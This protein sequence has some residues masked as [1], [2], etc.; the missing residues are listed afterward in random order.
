MEGRSAAVAGRRELE[1]L[2]YS[3]LNVSWCGPESTK[4]ILMETQNR[5]IIIILIA[6][7][8]LARGF[9]SLRLRGL[10]TSI[11]D[12]WRMGFGQLQPYT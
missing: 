3:P 5:C 1:T 6:A 12:L 11:S 10:Q 7:I 8:L 9:P 4:P 2:G